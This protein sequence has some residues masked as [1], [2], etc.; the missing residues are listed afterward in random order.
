M[1][2]FLLWY[3]H[4]DNRIEWCFDNFMYPVGFLVLQHFDSHVY[5]DFIFAE[6]ISKS[7]SNVRSS[8]VQILVISIA[9]PDK[10]VLLRA[11]ITSSTVTLQKY[12]YLAALIYL[13]DIMYAYLAVELWQDK[14]TQRVIILVSIY[15]KQKG[16]I[17]F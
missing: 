8:T 2:L 16:V 17:F 10:L 11:I 14:N 5:F 1:K 15:L 6:H 3:V 9:K 12:I 4:F 13:L 7:W